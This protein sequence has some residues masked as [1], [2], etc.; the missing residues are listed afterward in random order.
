MD[1]SLS[2]HNASVEITQNSSFFRRLLM[3]SGPAF[4]VSVG[5]MDPGNWATDLAGGAQFGYKLIWVILLANLMAILFQTLSARLG[6]V[7]GKDLAQACRDHYPKPLTFALWIFCEVA[8]AACDLAEVIGSAIGL[9]LLF[10]IPLL[11]GV[12]ITTFDVLLLM[13]LLSLGIRK[14]EAFIVALISTIGL[15]FAVELFFAKPVIGEVMVGFVPTSLPPGALFIALG[16][17]GAT[18]MPHNL[19]LHSALVQSRNIKNTDAGK[20]QA[21]KFNFIDSFIALNGAFFVNAAILIVAASVFFK[22]GHPE[23][24]SLVDAHR[25]LGNLIGNSIAPIAFGLALLAAGQ[26]STITGTF[27]GQIVMEGFVGLKMRPWLRRLFTRILAVTPAVLVLWFYGDSSVDSLLIVSQVILSLQLPFAIVPL[28]YFTSSKEK[29]KGFAN[30]PII[31]ILAWASA[32]LL[33]SLN[34]K[35]ITDIIIEN[36]QHPQPQSWLILYVLFPVSLLL[37]PILIWVIFEPFFR[38]MRELAK[39]RK[40]ITADL[41]AHLPNASFKKVGI[42]LEGDHGKDLQIVKL[43]LPLLCSFD[44]EVVLIHCVQTAPGLY[45]GNMVADREALVKADYLKDIGEILEKEKLRVIT[46][47]GGGDPEEEIVRIAHEQR[48]DMIITGS[49]GHRFISD[50]IYGSTVDG[51]RH[52][53][54]LPVLAFPIN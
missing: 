41:I 33:L 11:W 38:K 8:I 25:L 4:M 23:V 51:V 53:T 21:N 1:K 36:F 22:N 46:I 12:V 10:H 49:H 6:I 5:Y 15:C 9:Y 32:L 2:D 48:L 47:I 24:A 35:F 3:F 54:R 27:A 34:L 13:G 44:C 39:E 50:L 20:K 19:Y 37:L 45:M 31:K 26:S 28:I 42:A 17:I 7:T 18:V 43:A 16:I 14:M 52:K 40:K 29:M 30:K